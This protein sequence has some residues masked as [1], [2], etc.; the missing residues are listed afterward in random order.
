MSLCVFLSILLYY[1]LYKMLHGNVTSKL[2]ID[3]ES[4]VL[5]KH[6]YFVSILLVY[7]NI[8]VMYIF[9]GIV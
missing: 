7:G 2:G 6:M 9:F 5:S 1:C 4:V 8:S 3:K